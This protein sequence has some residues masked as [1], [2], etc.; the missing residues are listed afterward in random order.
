[1][2]DWQLLVAVI[3]SWLHHVRA[4]VL[5][6][7][8]QLC[9]QC[10]LSLQGTTCNQCCGA[11]AESRGAEIKLPPGAGVG[12]KVT[13]YGSGSFLLTTGLEEIYGRN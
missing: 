6:Q 3:Q 12:A 1:V 9:L 4:T 8:E 5:P 10:H 11:G 7:V 2:L 13:N